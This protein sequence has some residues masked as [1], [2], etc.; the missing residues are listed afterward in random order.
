MVSKIFYQNFPS[1][2]FALPKYARTNPPPPPPGMLFSEALFGCAC[3]GVIEVS[4]H[5]KERG[6]GWA[7]VGSHRD[8]WASNI[9]ISVVCAALLGHVVLSRCGKSNQLLTDGVHEARS[10]ESPV[11]QGWV[12]PLDASQQTFHWRTPG[13]SG[14]IG[15]N[16]HDQVELLHDERCSGCLLIPILEFWVV[17]SRVLLRGILALVMPPETEWFS[18]C[19]LSDWCL[20]PQQMGFKNGVQTHVGYCGG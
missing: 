15:E 4:V 14:M 12:V 16:R 5:S 17:Q 19:C 10:S 2:K 3:A 11:Q 13:R 7:L 1:P 6:W 8:V 18:I 20:V 9:Y